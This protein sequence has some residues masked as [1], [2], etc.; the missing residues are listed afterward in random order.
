MLERL[1]PWW[2]GKLFVLCLIGF[3]ATSFI[4]T[5]TLSAADATAHVI[6]NPFIPHW[7]DHPVL[8]TLLLIALLGGV[9]LRGFKEAI[10]IAVGVVVVYILLS[11]IVVGT[12]IYQIVREPFRLADW[13]HALLTGHGSILAMIG[14]ALLVFPR[15]ALG[16]SGFETGVVVM[17]L[18]RGDAGDDP[19][20]PQGRIRNTRTLLTAAALIM[21]F[22]LLSSSFVT[23]LLIPPGAFQEGGP[24]YGRALAYLAHEHLG[25]VFG[26]LYDISTIAILWFAGASAMAGLLNIVPRYLPRYGM[27]PEWTRATRPLV[28]IFTTICF[29]VTILFRAGVESQGG[30][31]ATGVLTLMGSAA[32]AVTLSVWRSGRR[33]LTALFA[34]VSLI[35][36]YTIIDNVVE[37]PDGLMIAGLF[38][39]GIVITSLISRALRSTELRVEQ[40]ELDELAWQFVSQIRNGTPRLIANQRDAGD[41]AEY[42]AKERE[43]RLDTHLPASEPVYFLEVVV[44]DSSEFRDVLEVHGVEVDGYRIFRAESSAVPNAIAAFLL[45]LRDQTG[46]CPHVYFEW[47]EAN[48]AKQIGRFLLLGEGDIPPLTREI[49]RRAEKD[50]EQRPAVHVGG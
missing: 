26:T 9:F 43:V 39:L 37:R 4:I 23:T 27:A 1:L 22:M 16:L 48:P 2:Q 49:L 20:V 13:Q 3:A 8:I 17:P 7:L 35:F 18:V 24:A 6:E 50:P 46:Q 38:I 14:A 10:G 44:P 15:L 32:I 36:I 19:R 21:S 45:Y 11:L 5:I 42:R 47:G 25:E 41:E 33:W 30:A 29:I 31:Y 12:G 28:L 34:V 40:V